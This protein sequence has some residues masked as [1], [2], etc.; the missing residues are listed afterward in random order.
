MHNK[1][2]STILYFPPAPRNLDGV[3]K[4]SPLWGERFSRQNAQSKAK[5]VAKAL[6]PRLRGRILAEKIRLTKE[7]I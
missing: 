7:K 2:P 6:L 5:G 3:V 4:F 1:A